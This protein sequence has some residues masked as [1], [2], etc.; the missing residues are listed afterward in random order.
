MKIS[1]QYNLKGKVAIITGA[2]DGIGRASALKLAQAGATVVC[3]DLDLEKAQET[4]VMV[5]ELGAEGLA[6]KCNVT[7][8]E[9]MKALVNETV[10]QFGKVNILV[11]NAGGG[12]GGKEKLEE[13]TLDY[14]TFIYKLNVFSV[15]TL[16]KLC[17]PHMRKD[18]YGSIINISSMASNMVSHNM[19]VYGSS[20]AAINQLTKYAAY[21]LGPEI[22]VNAIGPGAIKTRALGTVLTPEIEQKMLVKTPI[23]R[24]GEAEDIADAVLY[25]ASPASSWTSGQIIFVNGGGTQELD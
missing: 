4:V 7:V 15:F 23:K 14:I 12:G 2:G 21:D 20:K 25:F 3:S 19:S 11:N 16:M 8:E 6:I 10:K 18:G 17:A 1:E 5:K 22:R 13:L 24:L 9:D